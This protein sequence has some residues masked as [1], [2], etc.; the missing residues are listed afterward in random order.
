M[1]GDNSGRLL[2]RQDSPTSRQRRTWSAWTMLSRA[3]TT[4]CSIGARWKQTGPVMRKC[5]ARMTSIGSGSS[6]RTTTRPSRWGVV[7]FPARVGRVGHHDGRMH[8]DAG[9]HD[10]ADRHVGQA[11][12]ASCLRPASGSRVRTTRG[13][14]GSPASW[15]AIRILNEPGP[16]NRR[17]TH[18]GTGAGLSHKNGIVDWGQ[19]TESANSP[20]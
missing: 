15:T 16:A 10:G 4:R 8:G 5:A 6:S 17:L 7:H 13:D 20:S 14:V 2:C 18:D 3:S 9:R 12:G 19:V 11:V 1:T